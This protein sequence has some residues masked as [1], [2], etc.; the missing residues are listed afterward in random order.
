MVVAPPNF[1]LGTDKEL[2]LTSFH[3]RA[4]PRRTS[5]TTS[6]KWRQ[7]ALC[8]YCGVTN[9]NAETGLNHVRK[10]LDV[11]LVCGGCHTKSVRPGQALQKHTKDNCPAILA[12]PGKTRC[13]RRQ[14][15]PD[16]SWLRQ[17][18]P[19]MLSRLPLRE[20]PRTF[21]VSVIQE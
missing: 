7:V 13:G 4:C 10:H 15:Q 18:E 14:V 12:I 9:D 21:P 8:P 2:M 1:P 3:L 11:M 6:G 19:W 5:L 20:P 17:K 16:Y